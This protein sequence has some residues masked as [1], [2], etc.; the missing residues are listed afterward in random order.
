MLPVKL[1]QVHAFAKFFTHLSKREKTVFYAALAI[2]FVMFLDRAL[3]HP[4][5]SKISAL[6]KEIKERKILIT[7]DLRVLAQ[8]NRILSEVAQYT[9]FIGKAKTEEEQV[10]LILKEIENAATKSSAY[11]VDMKPSGQKTLG[12]I[13]KYLVTVN[14]EA[15][16]QQLIAFMYEIESSNKLL[17][18]EKYQIAQKSKE[19]GIAK[20]TMTI[21]KIVMP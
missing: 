8:K 2:V 14:C 6:N 12:S 11:L 1:P 18:V 3:I 7:Q 20:C 19:S 21:A 17:T 16:M 9:L 15:Q 5:S 4:V 13:K 10:T